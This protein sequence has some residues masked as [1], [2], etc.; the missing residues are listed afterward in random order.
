MSGIIET[1]SNFAIYLIE[2]LGYWGVFIGMTIESACI[3]LPSEVIMPLAGY[4][5]YEG[6]MSLIGITIVG[7]F[8]NLLGSWIAYFVGLK[9]GRPFLEKYGKYVLIS[10]RKLEM[11]HDWFDRYGHE[12][13]LIS[14]VLPVI[15]TF[16][17]LPAGIAEMDFKKFTV[18]T[19]LGSIPWCFA[20]GY[21]GYMLGPNWNTI[22]K[23]FRYMDIVVVIAVVALIAYLVYKYWY[24]MRD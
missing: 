9:G 23:Y 10:H 11:A 16:I 15:R 17:S 13:V 8:G 2:N 20:L 18:Y 7:A 21:I 19:L 12:A 6:K 3:P 1:V 24:K 22:E 14:R 4:V 5:A